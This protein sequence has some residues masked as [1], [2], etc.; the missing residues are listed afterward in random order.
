VR[1]LAGSC[2]WVAGREAFVERVESDRGES[3]LRRRHCLHIEFLPD[4][5]GRPRN[6]NI[7]SLVQILNDCWMADGALE[8]CVRSTSS[9]AANDEAGAANVRASLACLR[10]RVPKFPFASSL[11]PL[12]F[13]TFSF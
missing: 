9:G 10:N 6:E 5:A 3:R 12:T 11:G 13:K 1:G 8:A 2:C 4:R 7:F